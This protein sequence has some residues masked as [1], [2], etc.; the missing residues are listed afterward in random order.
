MR[1]LWQLDNQ[2][3]PRSSTAALLLV[4][5]A[6]TPTYNWREIVVEPT[7][8]HATF[9]CK[10]DRVERRTAFAPGREVVLHAVGCETGGAAFAVVW[11]EFPT[12]ELDAA[13][14]QWRQASL[15][16]SK[17]TVNSQQA[18]APA[19]ALGLPSSV[20]VR[21]TG[22]HPDGQPVQTQ[23]AYFARGTMAFQAVV[24]AATLKPDM[25][26]PFFSGLR[27]E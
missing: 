18:F 15:A 13:L 10:P 4:L 26:E 3:M 23:A 20:T 22:Q 6:C 21:A 25:T 5:A 11:A 8:L 19:G 2:P 27:F 14:T 9:P 17:S 1:R 7:P 16:A 12:A 24:Y